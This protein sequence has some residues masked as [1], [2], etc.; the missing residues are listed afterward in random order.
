M[1]ADAYGGMGHTGGPDIGGGSTTLA[2]QRR[3]GDAM[4]K[5]PST[6]N[7]EIDR[8]DILILRGE[9]DQATVSDLETKISKLL[10]PGRALVLDLARLTFLATAGIN[11]FVNAWKASGERV[12]LRDAPNSIRRVLWLTDGRP[13][14]EA[15]VFEC[16]GSKRSEKG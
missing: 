6:F 16:T 9:L 7:V 8:S 2:P 14:P 3:R 5:A 13:E 1:C 10:A 12:V 15:W 4:P 11:C